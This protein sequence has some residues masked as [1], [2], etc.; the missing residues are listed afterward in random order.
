[1]YD[2]IIV[3][4][5]IAG[6]TAAREATQK[7]KTVLLL[8][9]TD[10]IG[11]RTWGAS[12]NGFPIEY[13]GGYVYWSQPHVWAEIMRYGLK[14]KERPYYATT[15]SM[16]KTRFL[17]NGEVRFEFSKQEIEDIAAAFAEYIAPAQDVFP[18]P[19]N[20]FL[21]DDYKKWDKMSNLDRINSLNLTPLQRATL[22]RTS[23]IQCHNSPENGSFAE[24]LRWY[25]AAN[26]H[27]DTY[28]HTLSRF[29]IATGTDSLLQCILKD[30]TADIKTDSPVTHITQTADNVEVVANGVS[31]L[32]KAC[33]VATSLNVW[34]NINFA[35]SIAAEKMALST[36]EHSGKG[37][38][39]YVQIKG[40][41]QENR[42]SATEEPIL[43]VLPQ[44]ISDE[45]SILVVFSNPAIPMEK[46]DHEHIQKYLR[47]FD[48]T[49][50]LL[51]FT[52]NDWL[53]SP[54]TLGT[55]GNL[56]PLQTTNYLQSAQT[57][58]NRLFFAGSDI[59]TGWRG[60]IDGAIES[61]TKSARQVIES[62]GH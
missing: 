21:T 40:R 5:G 15:N 57:P 50:E 58:E 59:A 34:K 16:Q 33:I 60:F 7:G 9:A 4:G 45:S 20:Q 3:G 56:R 18:E 48:P 52:Y 29:T 26:C 62:L 13:G 37:Y 41:F 11:G 12:F 49:I 39:I 31:H 19:Y 44:H 27:S 24:T 42:W 61:G 46:I 43:S 25:A 47:R 36:E 2:I 28:A 1:M 30:T 14:I 55:W 54:Y 53:D 32:A 6:V 35:P 23:S 10:R 8:E 38:K 22:I 51:D 17:L